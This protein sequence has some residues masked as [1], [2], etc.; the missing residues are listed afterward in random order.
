MRYALLVQCNIP[1]NVTNN[2]D[3]ADIQAP[4]QTVMTLRS[5]T[6]YNWLPDI[7]AVSN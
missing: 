6:L 3:R 2:H 7:P 4:E 5:A 1:S